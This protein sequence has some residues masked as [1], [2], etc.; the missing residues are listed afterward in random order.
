[1][2]IEFDSYLPSS[3]NALVGLSFYKDGNNW[4]RLGTK[5]SAIEYGETTNGAY[6]ESDI[7]G[8]SCTNKHLVTS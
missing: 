6:A 1:M 7:S 4:G 8:T 3:I 5:P 2:I